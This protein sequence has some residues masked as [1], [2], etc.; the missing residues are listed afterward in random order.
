M[1]CTGLASASSGSLSGVRPNQSL[2]QSG[3]HVAVPGLRRSAAPA[4]ELCRSAAGVRRLACLLKR[5]AM[6]N[7]YPSCPL[8]LLVGRI[9]VAVGLSVSWVGSTTHTQVMAAVPD[10]NGMTLYDPDP[11]HLWNRLHQALHLRFHATAIGTRGYA[12]IGSST[13]TTS[14]R[15][16]GTATTPTC[17]SDPRPPGSARPLGRVPGQKGG[18]AR[19]GAA[20][21]GVPAARPLGMFDWTPDANW[22]K[23]DE[24]KH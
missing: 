9:L 11:K 1:T 4:A 15:F 10:G 7:P 24:K 20:Q 23:L 5:S 12:R 19:E 16:S 2:Q 18:S 22:P 6:R 14:T 3:P 8:S 17:L 21:A 13:R